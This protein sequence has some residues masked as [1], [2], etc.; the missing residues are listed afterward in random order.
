MQEW[1]TVGSDLR[2]EFVYKG[3][4]GENISPENGSL[5]TKTELLHRTKVIHG[6]YVPV[7]MHKVSLNLSVKKK[8]LELQLTIGLECGAWGAGNITK[9]LNKRRQK[10]ES[11]NSYLWNTGLTLSNIF[12]IY[13]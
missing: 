8:K 12:N 7:L 4:E 10:R 13:G 11:F 5:E 9:F 1:C 6:G 2:T 3:K